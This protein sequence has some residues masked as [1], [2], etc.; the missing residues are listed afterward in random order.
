MDKK[1]GDIM[2]FFDGMAIDE[3]IK[4]V[5]T[6]KPKVFSPSDSECYGIFPGFNCCCFF[7]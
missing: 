1:A 2:R 7:F 3:I 4:T 5:G 6:E